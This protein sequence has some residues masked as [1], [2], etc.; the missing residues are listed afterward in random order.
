[1]ATIESNQLAALNRIAAT[2]GTFVVN[3]N[4]PLTEDTVPKFYAI[5]VVE[6]TTIESLSVNGAGGNHITDYVLEPT[7]SLKAGAIITCKSGYFS[8]ITLEGGSVVLTLLPSE[9]QYP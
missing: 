7:T 5:Y 2:S 8:G 4:D 3:G 1:M 9:L 6:P